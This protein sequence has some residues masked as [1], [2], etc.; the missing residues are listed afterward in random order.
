MARAKVRFG[1][2]GLSLYQLPPARGRTAE[3]NV[4]PS[5]L[6]GAEVKKRGAWKFSVHSKYKWGLK[7][8][9]L[10]YVRINSVFLVSKA[11]AKE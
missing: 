9:V 5:R 10:D 8:C 4:P 6:A 3:A 2:D 11:R 1:T 7:N